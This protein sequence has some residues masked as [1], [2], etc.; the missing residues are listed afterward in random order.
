MTTPAWIDSTTWIMSCGGNQL[1][2]DLSTEQRV[3]MLVVG[4]F[5]RTIEDSVTQAAHA[6]HQLD[7]EQSAKTEDGFALALGVG[8]KAQ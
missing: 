3:D 6:W 4:G 7:T 2:V 5:G 1:P 8:V